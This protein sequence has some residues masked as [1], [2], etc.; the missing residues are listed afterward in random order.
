MPFVPDQQ[1][2][3]RFVPDEPAAPVTAPQQRPSRS[4]KE[5][6]MED[7]AQPLGRLGQLGIKGVNDSAA[8]MVNL[9]ANPAVALRNAAI[10]ENTEMPSDM[11][12]RFSDSTIAPP[13]GLAEEIPYQ[14][15]GAAL[16]TNAPNVARNAAPV[17]TDMLERSLDATRGAGYKIPPS[18]MGD[19]TTLIAKAL[20]AFGGKKQVASDLTKANQG[21]ITENLGKE[22]GLP[23]G[24]EISPATLD[25]VITSEGKGYKEIADLH[26]FFQQA[27][28]QVKLQRN[29]A[30]KWFK[31]SQ[32]NYSVEAEEKAQQAWQS[33]Q[34]TDGVIEQAL[35]SMG[36]KDLFDEY[37]QS[38]V[39]IAKAFDAQKMLDQASGALNPKS[40]ASAF[41]N[42]KPLS[43]E[44]AALGQSAKLAPEAFTTKATEKFGLGPLD[45]LLAGSGVGL[46]LMAQP[47]YAALAAALAGG[48]LGARKLV[49]SELVQDLPL[50]NGQRGSVAA[51]ALLKALIASGP[52]RQ[53]Q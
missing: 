35:Q 25:A 48:R 9:V 37:Q 26:P 34:Q 33:A 41:Q 5:Q 28:D 47:K 43:G 14:G 32:A 13:Q 52:A 49:G 39:Q 30:Q 36:R 45:G 11:W 23:A 21:R 10:G 22:F 1:A 12:K 27:I 7:F 19:K 44:M 24:T 3:S 38:R 8:G 50:V 18:A 6:F 40:V 2:T 20:E 4:F 51:D 31:Q 17:A 42:G 53:E 15:A 29:K 16:G 46:G